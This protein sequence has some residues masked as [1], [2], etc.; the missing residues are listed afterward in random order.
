[1]AELTKFSRALVLNTTRNIKYVG[2]CVCS[3]QIITAHKIH[4]FLITAHKIHVFL[5]AT[6][7][8]L[9]SYDDVTQQ[10]TLTDNDL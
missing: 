10:L 9:I 8:N 7:S 6:L 1:M 2:M 4:V 3:F 5:T